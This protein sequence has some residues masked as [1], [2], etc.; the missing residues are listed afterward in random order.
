LFDGSLD[1]YSATELRAGCPL[2][3][4]ATVRE[5]EAAY[6]Q[7]CCELWS[8]QCLDLRGSIPLIDKNSIGAFDR[9][10]K[11]RNRSNRSG[12]I[13]ESVVS[14]CKFHTKIASQLLTIFA[15]FPFYGQMM[16]QWHPEGIWKPSNHF[17]FLPKSTINHARLY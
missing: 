10:I 17:L 13:A 5:Q 6:S 1:T 8:A 7:R 9:R 4:G 11:G 16:P 15:I 2:S 12:V 14:P 3:N